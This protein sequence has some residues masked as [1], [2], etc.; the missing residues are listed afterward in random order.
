M[1][2][3]NFTS[4]LILL[5]G[6][7]G[8]VGIALTDGGNQITG[9]VDD[10]ACFGSSSSLIITSHHNQW[11]HVAISWFYNEIHLFLNGNH[12][13]NCLNNSGP[14]RIGK[15]IFRVT[16]TNPAYL[17]VVGPPPQDVGY[18]LAVGI[19]NIWDTCVDSELSIGGFM[20][21]SSTQRNYF[22]RATF[23]WPMSGLLTSL[24]P[25][26]IITSGVER[27][28]DKRNVEG[29]AMCT[30][31]TGG[32]YVVLT[33]DYEVGRNYSNLYYSCI[34]DTNQCHELLFIVDFRL[35]NVLKMKNENFTLL[36]TPPE[37][38]AVG[39]AISINPMSETLTVT[40]RTPK[41]KC[42]LSANIS[43]AINAFNDWI[44]LQAFISEHDIRLRINEEIV[45]IQSHALCN[46]EQSKSPSFELGPFPRILIGQEIELCV[47]DVVIIEDATQVVP[48]LYLN[49]VCYS[50]SDVIFPLEGE[51]PDRLG[52]ANK[53]TDF[54]SFTTRMMAKKL[55]NCLSKFM[56]LCSE[57]TISFWMNIRSVCLDTPCVVGPLNTYCRM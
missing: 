29:G 13:S 51:Q 40:R 22:A 2:H 56:L 44:N 16:E 32:S 14:K 15:E 45:S 28:K 48:D 47:S 10:A 31:G 39:I 42:S 27:A 21:L 30:A 17:V 1:V 9:W 52:R 20:G 25:S 26:R 7:G 24:A 4:P 38:G 37:D 53:A 36:K 35:D 12:I 11:F 55:N 6:N 43:S 33:G 50:G 49:D 57:F 23:Y 46:I 8:R 41:S 54:S 34:Y 3:T 5:T 18:K 19:I